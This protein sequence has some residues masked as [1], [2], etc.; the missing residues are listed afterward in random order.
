MLDMTTTRA[1]AASQVLADIRHVARRIAARSGEMESQRRIPADI[2]ADLR[3][4]G[5]F[6]LFVS[7]KQGGLELDLMDGL[8]ILVELA[9][10][11]GS[12]GWNAM[13]STVISVFAPL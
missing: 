10:I 13:T 12:V 9:K 8:R 3:A 6:R 2:M 4:A 7:R 5:V 11:D 1:G